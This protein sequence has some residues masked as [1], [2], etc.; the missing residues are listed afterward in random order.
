MVTEFE[1][2]VADRIRKLL[3]VLV[4]AGGTVL[5]LRVLF[6]LSQG[7]QRL[8]DPELGLFLL[9]TV[10][11]ILWIRA[12]RRMPRRAVRPDSNGATD[13]STPDPHPPGDAGV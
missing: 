12:T 6:R 8:L 9:L 4:S 10:I 2:R 3:T 13:E 7:R 1:A 5:L 11:A